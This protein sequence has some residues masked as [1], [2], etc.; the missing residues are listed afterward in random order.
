MNYFDE[1][2][3]INLNTH[4]IGFE[5]LTDVEHKLILEKMN[6]EIPFASSKIDWENLKNGHIFF[7]EPLNIATLQLAEKIRE[8][9]AGNL[10][11]VGDSACD[12]A[13]SITPK[14]L[15]Q[16]L[17]LFSEL[18]QHTYILQNSLNWIACISFEGDIDFA[19]LP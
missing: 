13:Y 4:N 8:L 3:T 15:E 7:N 10:I 1:E 5:T 17:K 19:L 2:I 18:P 9:S 12:E 11:F 16:A 6:N 14:N